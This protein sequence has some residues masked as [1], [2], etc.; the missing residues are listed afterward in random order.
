MKKRI[1]ATIIAGLMSVTLFSPTAMAAERVTDL[2]FI[3]SAT[4]Q[5]RNRMWQADLEQLRDAV[6][7]RHGMFWDDTEIFVPSD[8]LGEPAGR[9]TIWMQLERNLQLKSNTVAAIDALIEEVPYLSDIE[10]V[11]GMQ[12]AIA[13]MQDSH[14]QILPHDITIADAHLPV[15]FMHFGGHD[16]GY[17]L[18]ATTDEFAHALNHR[19]IYINDVSIPDIEER[20]GSVNATEN[21]YALRSSLGAYYFHSDFMLRVLGLREGGVTH[22]VLENIEGERV[23]IILDEAH[24]RTFEDTDGTSR[25]FIDE[26]ALAVFMSVQE[27]ADGELPIFFES[28]NANRFYLLEDYGIL[29][30]RLE[31]YSPTVLVGIIYYLYY[32][33]IDFSEIFY[34]DEV[35]PEII[36]EIEPAI[37]ENILD[38][39]FQGVLW[40]NMEV[41]MTQ[42]LYHALEIHPGIIEILENNNI[43]AV[44]IDSRDNPGGDHTPFLP[45]FQLLVD[46]VPEGRLFYFSN[47]GSASAS[48]VSSMVMH[49]LGAVL[50]GEPLGQ[51]TIFYGIGTWTGMPEEVY[52][53]ITLNYS[54]IEVTIPNLLAHMESEMLELDLI[55]FDMARFLEVTPNFEFY[56]FRPHVLIEHTIYHWVNNIDPLLE[57]VIEQVTPAASELISNISFGEIGR[58]HLVHMQNYLPNRIAFTH[59]E[60]DTAQWIVSELQ[61]IGYVD[62]DIYIQDFPFPEFL[63]PQQEDDLP[64]MWDGLEI[65]E[66]S[67]NIIAVSRGTS[68]KIIVV[69]AHYDSVLTPGISDNGSGVALVLE[70]AEHIFNQDTYYTIKYVFFGA[71]EVGILG[72]SYFVDSLTD[73]QRDNIVLMINADVLFDYETLFFATG[74]HNPET[75]STGHNNVSRQ[76]KQ[77]A[78]YLDLGLILAD[79]GIYLPS[80]QLS[81]VEEGFTVAVFYALSMDAYSPAQLEALIQQFLENYD[82]EDLELQYDETDESEE[83]GYSLQWGD[84]LHTENDNLAYIEA[85]Y[86]GRIQRALRNYGI[87]LNEI[88][89]LSNLGGYAYDTHEDSPITRGEFVSMLIERFSEDVGIYRHFFNTRA[90]NNFDDVEAGHPFYNAILIARGEG[91]IH[92]DSSGNFNPDGFIS[93]AQAAVLLNNILGWNPDLVTYN[94]TLNLPSWAVGAANVLLDLQMVSPRLIAQNTLTGEDALTFIDA[95]ERATLFFDSPYTLQQARPQD[96][97]WMYVH[98]VFLANADVSEEV[99]RQEHIIEGPSFDSVWEW[100]LNANHTPGSY[101]YRVVNFYNM[102]LDA[103]NMLAG[104]GTLNVMFDGLRAASDMEEFIEAATLLAPYF[105]IQQFFNTNIET[106]TIR[107][108]SYWAAN[109]NVFYFGLG[110]YEVYANEEYA[111]YHEYFMEYMISSLRF[112]GEADD[113][114]QR[115]RA[116][117]ELEKYIYSQM[118]SQADY[119]W[120]NLLISWEE[121][122]ALTPNSRFFTHNQEL[123]NALGGKNLFASPYTIDW[124]AAVDSI[125]VDENIDILV[126]MAKISFLSSLGMHDEYLISLVDAHRTGASVYDNAVSDAARRV[127]SGTFRNMFNQMYIERYAS[128]EVR[129]YISEMAESLR[130]IWRERLYCVYWLSP[131]TIEEARAKLDAMVFLISHPEDGFYFVMPDFY[132]MQHG[133]NFAY[134]VK[135]NSRLQNQI[136]IDSLLHPVDVSALMW[137]MMG[138]TTYN[139]MYH[140]TL[141]ALV[142]P[143]GFLVYP[144]FVEGRAREHNLGGIGTT[145][146]HEILHGFGY[147]SIGFDAHGIERDWWTDEDRA[148]FIERAYA[149]TDMIS[150]FF[151]IDTYL[152]GSV[153]LDEVISDVSGLAAV[154]ALA[155]HE[156]LDLREVMYAS[157]RQWGIRGDV[158]TA[159]RYLDGGVHPPSSFRANFS[160]TMFDIFH[161]IFGIQPGDGMYVPREQRVLIW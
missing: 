88:L 140:L 81:F 137:D 22:F 157:V 77:L 91:L 14:F 29:Y 68:D 38:G 53:E 27:R 54:G 79:E 121:L 120:T 152:D 40:P 89:L 106:D 76:I 62:D 113:L 83:D 1:L 2:V 6:I 90:E 150:R 11:L 103:D 69:G 17:Y 45:L 80:D 12:V 154:F 20:F 141:N 46:S 4:E 66:T 134:V 31:A 70:S 57:Y 117:F 123:L 82:F 37:R 19:V 16:G 145:I 143:M 149:L 73:E 39:T 112:F 85:T 55:E 63:R 98:R 136:R 116:I 128:E 92:G 58:R 51:N 44:V 110:S 118:G 158:D 127:V 107:G 159:S 52:P 59:N 146:G 36:A 111:E 93:G 100:L 161:E 41:D 151:W 32:L 99:V 65:L 94:T 35:D 138:V 124:V 155:E 78:E 135:G 28:H 147:D 23:E 86:P 101:Y 130:D 50:V 129:T 56:T 87:F 42:W 142:V 21:I 139:A 25:R 115:A 13:N 3:E 48:I 30:I 71:E 72:A 26:D 60:R 148:N 108:N 132:S 126:D 96:D 33:D 61:R 105:P 153:F 18:I 125:F 8:I 7:Q 133:G 114:E 84:V 144:N 104:I 97:L 75:N 47:G 95:I 131:S 156:G 74:Y 10:I 102:L 34:E 24:Q 15:D 67:Q 119:E 109:I 160:L 49:H 5:E 9:F 64:D 43:E 122:H